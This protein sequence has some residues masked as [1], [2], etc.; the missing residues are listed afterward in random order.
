MISAQPAPAL[1]HCSGKVALISHRRGAGVWPTWCI[2]YI[3]YTVLYSVQPYSGD[4]N[5]V[6]FLCLYNLLSGDEYSM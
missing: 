4:S 3:L 2:L 6:Y 5:C 1:Q